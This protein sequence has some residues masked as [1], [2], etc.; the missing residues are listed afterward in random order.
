M[1]YQIWQD[2]LLKLH[3]ARLAVAVDSIIMWGPS[4]RTSYLDVSHHVTRVLEN[5]PDQ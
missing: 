2:S 4:L 3:D 5:H 1:W